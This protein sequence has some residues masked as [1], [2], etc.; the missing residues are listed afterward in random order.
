MFDKFYSTNIDLMESFKRVL[1][2]HEKDIEALNKAQLMEGLR[3]DN[4]TLPPYSV[5][6]AKRKGKP[7]TPKTLRDKGGFQDG[8]FETFFQDSFNVE[9][10]DWK[11]EILESNWGKKIFGLTA[12]NKKKL[13]WGMGVA[14]E[15]FKLTKEKIKNV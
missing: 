6:Y 8:I 3:S 2:S 15:L 14:N 4:T 13:L 10:S 7:L 9:S 1:Q 12:D 11:S 5:P